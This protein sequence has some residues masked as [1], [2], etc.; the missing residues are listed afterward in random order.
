MNLFEIP[1]VVLLCESRPILRVQVQSLSYVAG[2]VVLLSRKTV[3]VECVTNTMHY[4]RFLYLENLFL[5][6]MAARCGVVVVL[7]PTHSEFVRVY[8]YR[9]SVGVG[10]SRWTVT[11]NNILC[12]LQ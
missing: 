4:A 6:M 2:A 7:V 1:K 5:G 8:S 11:E 12:K 10:L 3:T 9:G